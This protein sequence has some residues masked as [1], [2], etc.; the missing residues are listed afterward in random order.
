MRR[1]RQGGVRK[2]R[3]R[4]T[5]ISIRGGRR[6]IGP[7]S[8][9]PT[10]GIDIAQKAPTGRL[11]IRYPLVRSLDLPKAGFPADRTAPVAPGY[12][13]SLP[14]DNRDAAGHSYYERYVRRDLFDPDAHRNSLRELLMENAVAT[15]SSID[16]SKSGSLAA[17][18]SG[19]RLN[20][21]RPSGKTTERYVLPADSAAHSCCRG[22]QRSNRRTDARDS[23]TSRHHAIPDW[24]CTP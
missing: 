13:H 14:S 11:P 9:S 4:K 18:K 16:S 22:E 24:Q 23:V 17:S 1:F 5:L 21:R 20:V 12:Q 6:Q 7:R 2:L 19:N 8:R 10:R 15:V 3:I